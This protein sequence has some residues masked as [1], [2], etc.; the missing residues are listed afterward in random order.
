[1]KMTVKKFFCFSVIITILFSFLGGAVSVYADEIDGATIVADVEKPFSFFGNEDTEDDNPTRTSSY[2]IE[3]GVYYIRN[4]Y[5]G[6]YLDVLDH[7][8][9]NGTAIVQNAYTG[10]LSQQFQVQFC[11]DGYYIFRPLH[12]Y[13]N[14]AIDLQSA[15]AANTNGTTAQL[16]TYNSAY[17]EQKFTIDYAIFGGYQIG[18]MASDG[19]KVLGVVDSS[20][21]D[22][23]L[24]DIWTYTHTSMS[25]NWLFEDA[26]CGSAPTYSQI[27]T[28]SQNINCLG[29]ALR[30]NQFIDVNLLNHNSGASVETVATATINYFENN[31]PNRTIRRIPGVNLTPTYTIDEDEYRIALRVK[32]GSGVPSM[33]WDY[34][35][36]IQLNPSTAVWSGGYSSDVIY[37]AVSY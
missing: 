6:K 4:M 36:M 10:H 17:A 11:A 16:W 25:D 20:L 28:T 35:F 32:F 12:T 31:F 8:T 27:E 19:S 22:V 1:M 9:A 33:F 13:L 5:S 34:H 23:A 14:S 29:F 30:V 18:T 2:V 21:D 7:G 24:I 15:A 3:N 26:N 37:F